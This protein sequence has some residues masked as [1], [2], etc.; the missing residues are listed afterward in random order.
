MSVK[1]YQYQAYGLSVLSDL[2]FPEFIEIPASKLFFQEDIVIRF[3]AVP[4][5][6]LNHC[7]KQ[8]YGY[9]LNQ[10]MFWLNIPYIGRFLIESGQCIT[11]EPVAGVD[12]DSIRAFVLEPCMGILLIQRE[13]FVLHG[14]AMKINDQG[15][16]FLGDYGVGKSS[17]AATFLQQGH[18]ILTDGICA[19]NSKFNVVPSYPSLSLWYDTASYLNIDLVPL[20]KI[21]PKIDKYALPI[22]MQFDNQNTLVKSI[23][24]LDLYKKDGFNATP[25]SGSVKVKYLQKN[26]YHKGHLSALQKSSLYFNY[27]AEVAKNI[28]I[29]LIQRPIKYFRIQELANF[30]QTSG[31]F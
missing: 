22:A 5:E 29:V 17:L 1:V 10:S 24:I 9:Q 2:V 23:F 11:I 30:I 6:G 19:L 4:L 26:I 8:G 16:V 7:V 28:P 27:C 3:G 18:S 14:N 25:L 21:R 12:E 15:I 31:Y 13:L 20:R